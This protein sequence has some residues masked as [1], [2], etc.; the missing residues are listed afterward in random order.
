MDGLQRAL[1]VPAL[2]RTAL[3]VPRTGRSHQEPPRPAAGARAEAEQAAG[4]APQR[5]AVVP[6][7]PARGTLQRGTVTLLRA[8]HRIVAA[9]RPTRLV[10]RRRL[11]VPAAQ[12]HK[13]AQQQQ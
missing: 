7:R 9:H 12:Q 13:R 10:A 6:L 8:F 4:R 1:R 3:V 2:R 5:P 11:H